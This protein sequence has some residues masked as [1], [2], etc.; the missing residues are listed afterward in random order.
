ME[1]IGIKGTK[2]LHLYH[3]YIKKSLK[4]IHISATYNLRV[5]VIEHLGRKNILFFEAHV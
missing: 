2:L 5:E 3:I 1:G 4:N